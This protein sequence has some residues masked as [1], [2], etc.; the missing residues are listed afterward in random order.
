VHITTPNRLH[1]EMAVRALRA[2]KHV[3]CEKPLAMNALE[4]GK[5]VRLAADSKV[6]AAVAYNIR[7]YP[8]CLEARERVARQTGRQVFHVAG[9]YVQDWLLHKTD[10]NWRVVAAEGGKLRALADIG[11]HWLDLVQF[12]TGLRIVSLCAD[13]AT[14]HSTRRRPGGSVQ[15]FGGAAGAVSQYDDVAIDT[16]DAGGLLLEFENGARGTLWVSQVTAG[17][18]NCLR[19]EIACHDE[20]LAWNSERPDELWIGRRDSANELLLRDPALLSPLARSASSYP[21]GHNEGFPDTFKQLFRAFYGYIE[22]GNFSSPPP[23]PT[24]GDGHREIVL[25][26]AILESHRKRGWV[27]VPPAGESP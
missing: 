14:V 15:T 26:D 19:F 22:A 20:S 24:F 6:A 11:T 25:C 5:L 23:F 2:G 1:F 17:R 7:F 10:F 21:G 8:L 3:V 12:I 18:K 27:T 4:S 16:E 13:L 9:S